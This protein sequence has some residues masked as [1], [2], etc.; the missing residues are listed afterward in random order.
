MGSERGDRLFRPARVGGDA[1][2]RRRA[3]QREHPGEGQRTDDA[4]GPRGTA[5]RLGEEA[6]DAAVI[7]FPSALARASRDS[8]LYIGR[9]ERKEFGRLRNPRN[10]FDPGISWSQTT[11]RDQKNAGE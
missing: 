2:W 6:T 9:D 5:A 10:R 4:S 1:L 3:S 11:K 8:L 7:A